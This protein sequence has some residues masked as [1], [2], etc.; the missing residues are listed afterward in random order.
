MGLGKEKDLGI[1][2]PKDGPAL[3]WTPGHR[4]MRIEEPLRLAVL[5]WREAYSLVRSSFSL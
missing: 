2:G 3:A 5:G 4:A 1:Q